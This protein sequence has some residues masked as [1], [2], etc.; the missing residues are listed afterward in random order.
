MT[1]KSDFQSIR[2]LLDDFRPQE[3][4]WI[5]TEEAEQIRTALELKQRSAI[6]LQNI[7]DMTVLF[8]ARRSEEQRDNTDQVVETMDIM[9]AVTHVIDMERFSRGMEV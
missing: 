6:E 3:R 9:S 4:G 7:R 8:L 1:T 5:S 2:E